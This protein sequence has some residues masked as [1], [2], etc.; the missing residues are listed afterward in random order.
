MAQH[1]NS[2]RLSGIHSGNCIRRHSD[3]CFTAS[4]TTNVKP[5][6]QSESVLWKKSRR[7]LKFSSA[8]RQPFTFWSDFTANTSW[9]INVKKTISADSYQSKGS[10][11]CHKNE[12]TK[13]MVYWLSINWDK[14]TSLT[15]SWQRTGHLCAEPKGLFLEAWKAESPPQMN[16]RLQKRKWWVPVKNNCCKTNRI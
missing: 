4:M 9:A 12:Q 16:F 2:S 11:M 10:I 7:R 14:Q 13:Y 3:S 6:A 1:Y 8:F 5:G 15:L